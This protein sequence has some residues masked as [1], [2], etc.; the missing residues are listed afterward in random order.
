MN[1]TKVLS[2]FL[3]C[4]SPTLNA[5][6]SETLVAKVRELAESG[7][8]D[9]QRLM[10]ELHIGG[11]VAGFGKGAIYQNPLKPNPLQVEFWYVRAAAQG[12][13]S[14]MVSLS[15][16]YS[17][18]YGATP[19]MIDNRKR[20]IVMI[21]AAYSGSELAPFR[22][23]SMYEFGDGVPEDL[24]EAFA[25]HSVN[26]LGQSVH[27][28]LSQ[29]VRDRIRSKLSPEQLALASRRATQINHWL[30]SGSAIQ[31]SISGKS[32]N[33]AVDPRHAN[34]RLIE[35]AL[36]LRLKNNSDSKSDEANKVEILKAREDVAKS[37]ANVQ[38]LIYTGD[39]PVEVRYQKYSRAFDEYELKLRALRKLL[40]EQK[41][42]EMPR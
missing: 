9:A 15:D 32:R 1:F 30:A 27:S 6:D 12:D 8:V 10:A 14:S 34:L 20:L 36:G 7:D 18:A 16:L 38:R 37:F 2:I 26:A 39:E 40:E 31:L 3:M 24:I 23:A 17:G 28:G 11:G 29:R 4:L 13:V 21:M 33:S 5:H 19:E 22:L 42:A 25:W 41:G 35:R